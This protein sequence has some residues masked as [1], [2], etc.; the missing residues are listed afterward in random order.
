MKHVSNDYFLATVSEPRHNDATE[1][2]DIMKAKFEIDV[3]G[4]VHKFG[5]NLR[6]EE[7]DTPLV[8]FDKVD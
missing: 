1:V 2:A 4:V 8:W 6:M 3:T 7:L 5:I